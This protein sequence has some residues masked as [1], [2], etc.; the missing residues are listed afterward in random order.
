[1]IDLLKTSSPSMKIIQKIL[2]ALKPLSGFLIQLLMHL[3]SKTQVFGASYNKANA[4][5]QLGKEQEAIDAFEKLLKGLSPLDFEKRMHVMKDLAISYMRLGERT[6]CI[7]NHGA[8]SCLFPISPAGVHMDKTG[9]EK[10]IE[11][12][13]EILRD[14][15]GD[16]ES[17]WLLNIAYMT[18]GGYPDQVP[19][20]LL[21]KVTDDDS[22]HTI[23]PFRDVAANIGLNLKDMAGGSIV[24]DFNNDNYPDIVLSSWGLKEP[25]HYCRNNHDGTFTN[26]SDSSWLGYLTGGLNI[27][28]TDYNNDGF[29]DIFVLRGAWRM[30]FGATPNSLLRNNGDGTFTDVTKESGLLSFHPTQTATWADFNNDGWL[31]VF[32]GNETSTIGGTHP[33]ELYINNKNGTFTEQ[34]TIA[35]CAVTEF[36]KGVTSGDYDN[37]GLTDIFISVLNGKRI[38]LKNITGKNGP[39]RFADVTAQ[40]GLNTNIAGG[41]GTWF[42]DYDNDGWLDLLVCGY[43]F[44][45]PLGLLCSSRSHTC[46]NWKCRKGFSFS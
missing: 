32:I 10:A 15:P 5:L 39:V 18:V 16:L 27:M 46:T 37:D 17:R 11:L 45:E 22:L 40:S 14:N 33:C 12:Y 28:Q 23:K 35:G 24:E 20:G 31:D 34:A 25:M 19:P 29:K 7:N 8:E 42:F 6:N 2:L 36:V 43:E 3:P 41:F 44:Y 38:L 30:Q 21:L 1:M 9:S 4:L 13:K 26:V